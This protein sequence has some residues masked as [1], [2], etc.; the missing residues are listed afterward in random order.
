[1][2]RKHI[3]LILSVIYEILGCCCRCV[4]AHQKGETHWRWQ[5]IVL[6]HLP[7]NCIFSADWDYR[8]V[9]Y[10]GPD[11][12][13][14]GVGSH[15][16]FLAPWASLA[17]MGIIGK[18]WWKE[19]G[20]IRNDC[21]AV[22]QHDAELTSCAEPIHVLHLQ[23]CW[24]NRVLIDLRGLCSVRELTQ[25]GKEASFLLS[26]SW[27]AHLIILNPLSVIIGSRNIPNLSLDYVLFLPLLGTRF[28][29]SICI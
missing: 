29:Q 23:V 24:L 9:P 5:I 25:L 4:F 20:G 19:P 13:L 22:S 2:G 11:D 8:M 1:M 28:P 18:Q 3:R 17:E 12:L 14:S 6:C 7:S 21:F 15:T 10:M 27:W 26:V 16:E